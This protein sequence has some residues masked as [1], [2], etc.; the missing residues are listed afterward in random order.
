MF[1]DEYMKE[2]R[3]AM[4]TVK[5]ILTGIGELLMF[6]IVALL[7][8]SLVFMFYD[9]YPMGTVIVTMLVYAAILRYTK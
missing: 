8:F 7:A 2:N 6:G 5:S 3:D 4:Y 1:Y 9:T